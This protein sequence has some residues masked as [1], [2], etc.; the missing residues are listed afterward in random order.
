MFFFAS[1][2]TMCTSILHTR[3]NLECWSFTTTHVYTHLVH[4]RLHMHKQM[5]TTV[6]SVDPVTTPQEARRLQLML[7]LHACWRG[8]GGLWFCLCRM[9]DKG[10]AWQRCPLFGFIKNLCEC[11]FPFLIS[12]SSWKEQE[13]EGTGKYLHGRYLEI[14]DTINE[15][16]L[17]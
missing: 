17:R 16:V 6:T 3:Y 14:K 12:A 4:T 13:T 8:G 1:Y 11:G 5:H 9:V 7:T 15:T 2:R 10:T